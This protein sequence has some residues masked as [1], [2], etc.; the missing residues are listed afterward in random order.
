MS[1]KWCYHG[2][3][4]AGFFT[5]ESEAW[6]HRS[7]DRTGLA[8]ACSTNHFHYKVFVI[9]YMWLGLLRLYLAKE[10]FTIALGL[11]VQIHGY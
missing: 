6:L 11:Y 9:V 2:L 1:I 3:G 7:F 10:A 8:N 4:K 5:A